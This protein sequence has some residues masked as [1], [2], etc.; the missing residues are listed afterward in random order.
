[1]GA[2]ARISYRVPAGALNGGPIASV[3][4]NAVTM[5]A[6]LWEAPRPFQYLD[7]HRHFLAL[8]GHRASHFSIIR[9]TSSPKRKAMIRRAQMKS[10]WPQA[11]PIK[12]TE[13]IRRW[14]LKK[15]SKLCGPRYSFPVFMKIFSKKRNNRYYY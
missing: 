13:Y 10:A 12:K 2:L 14:K 5:K 15:N 3:T 1:M 6:K 11:P 7:R 8:R 4:K 9:S